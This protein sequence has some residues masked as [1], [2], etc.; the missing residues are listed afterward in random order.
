M[1]AV[2]HFNSVEFGSQKGADTKKMF[3]LLSNH[4][5]LKEVF[6]VKI[7]AVVLATSAETPDVPA[8]I[9]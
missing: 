4:F 2:F 7:A 5:F 9:A 1:G 3:Y 6:F 8:L